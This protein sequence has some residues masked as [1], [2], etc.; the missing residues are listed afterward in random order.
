ML[1]LYAINS[2]S[3][4]C[5]EIFI[6]YLKLALIVPIFKSGDRSNIKNFRPIFLLLIILKIFAEIMLGFF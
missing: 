2:V 3:V 1:I 6:I 4:S 5:A